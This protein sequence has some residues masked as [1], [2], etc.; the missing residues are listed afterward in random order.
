MEKPNWENEKNR[1]GE[2]SETLSKYMKHIWNYTC[3]ILR[4]PCG[5]KYILFYT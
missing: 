1:T 2:I 5:Y 4:I 3:K